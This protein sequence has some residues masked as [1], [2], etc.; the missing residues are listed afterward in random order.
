MQYAFD[1]VA[2]KSVKVFDLTGD[3]VQNLRDVPLT[4]G[5]R[6]IRLQANGVEAALELL[7]KYPDNYVELTLSITEPLTSVESKALNANENLVSLLVEIH[8]DERL[9]FES[10]K[11]LSDEELFDAFYKTSFGTDP[12]AELKT[13]F[14]QTLTELN[15]K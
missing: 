10:R 13:L 9:E 12:K 14:L 2:D 7:A 8:G 15:E 3:G 4:K 1:E 5:K 11:G 6:L